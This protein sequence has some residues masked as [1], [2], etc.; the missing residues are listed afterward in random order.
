[1]QGF[2]HWVREVMVPM[3]E[4]LALLTVHMIDIEHVDINE[5]FEMTFNQVL[6]IKLLKALNFY[7]VLIH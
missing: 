6:S 4:T 7:E 1:M 2:M 3:S 5:L